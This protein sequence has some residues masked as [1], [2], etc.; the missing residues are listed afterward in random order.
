MTLYRD[1]LVKA[2][3]MLGEIPTSVFVGQSVA[4]PGHIMTST[5]MDVV[6]RERIIELPVFEETQLGLSFG[7]LLE[8]YRPVVSVFP[9]LDFF[10]IAMNQLVNHLDKWP[11]MSQG[12]FTTGGLIIR[13]M[14]GSFYPL[15]S[16]PQHI[17]DHTDALKLMLTNVDVVKL[18]E[19]SHILPMYMKAL[20]SPRS[21]IL[22]EAPRRREGYEL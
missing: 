22:V 11:E 10:I 20:W 7:L 3:K 19:P 17:Q 16:G 6:P 21:T 15:Y 12:Q 4:Y 2:M 14:V 5:I 9:R 18:T 13:T 8:G 1:E